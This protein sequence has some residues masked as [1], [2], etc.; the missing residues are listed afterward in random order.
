[1][2]ETTQSPEER[3][4]NDLDE[5]SNIAPGS[6]EDSTDTAMEAQ[7]MNESPTEESHQDQP[8]ESNQTADPDTE[9]MDTDINV[10]E[11]SEQPMQNNTPIE[12]HDRLDEENGT[13][14]TVTDSIDQLDTHTKT[15]ETSEIHVPTEITNLNET[16][17]IEYPNEIADARVGEDTNPV[18]S[19]EVEYVRPNNE[20]NLVTDDENVEQAVADEIDQIAADHAEEVTEV[21]TNDTRTTDNL[22]LENSEREIQDMVDDGSDEMDTGTSSTVIIEEESSADLRKEDMEATHS[23]TACIN[24]I[25][26]TT[27]D[28]YNDQMVEMDTES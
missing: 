20:T 2:P 14:D 13:S 24:E 22:D 26:D 28:K 7:R 9:L 10:Q 11:I 6:D 23:T 16:S 27:T 25:S 12:K 8:S 1:M 4:F 15:D 19:E 21:K 18:E 17:E 5:N 3:N